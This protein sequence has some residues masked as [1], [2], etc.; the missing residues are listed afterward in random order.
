MFR[1]FKSIRRKLLAESKFSRYLLYALG[2]IALVVVGILIALQVNNWNEA[3]KSRKELSDILQTVLTDL[4]KDIPIVEGHIREAEA[5]IAL[6][7]SVYYEKIPPERLNTCFECMTAHAFYRT[8][9]LP[10][11]GYRMLA[12]YADLN[13]SLRDSLV[14][15]IL[16]FYVRFES[17][18]HTSEAVRS[19]TAWDNVTWIMDHVDFTLKEWHQLTNEFTTNEHITRKGLASEGNMKRMLRYQSLVRTDL[20]SLQFFTDRGGALKKKILER[21]L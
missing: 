5:K 1:F 14:N 6:I 7:D 3:R 9:S 8:L 19:Q 16:E 12:T 13:Q 10:N 4:D 18:N 21:P 17:A 20:I 15:E 11:K 2:E